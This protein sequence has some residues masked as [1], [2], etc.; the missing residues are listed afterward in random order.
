MEGDA[1]DKIVQLY[2][3][4]LVTSFSLDPPLLTASKRLQSSPLYGKPVVLR[5]LF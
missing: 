2:G 4:T 3:P 1:L 5:G